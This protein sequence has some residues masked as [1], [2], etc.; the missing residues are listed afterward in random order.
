MK[1]RALSRTLGRV[2]RG[3][4][5][6]HGR[7]TV[8]APE[9]VPR[10]RPLEEWFPVAVA[11]SPGAYIHTSA[12]TDT[13]ADARKTNAEP[14]GRH[15]R[16]RARMPE[17]FVS[18]TDFSP[19]LHI[20][21]RLGG[22][23]RGNVR[24]GGFYPTRNLSERFHPSEIAGS[25]VNIMRLVCVARTLSLSSYVALL[26]LLV[27]SIPTDVTDHCSISNTSLRCRNQ[28]A[29]SQVSISKLPFIFNCSNFS[30][31]LKYFFYQTQ[32]S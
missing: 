13:H 29:R 10:G 11:H 12:K 20:S 30:K 7:F 4:L 26:L 27:K 8:S 32:H 17:G 25:V 31:Y 1:I 22:I 14:A 9:R 6:C 16:I 23:L 3:R 5:A 28:Y 15:A 24:Q 2:P 19:C 18:K 21:E